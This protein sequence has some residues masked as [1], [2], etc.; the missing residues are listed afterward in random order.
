[1]IVKVPLVL[2]SCNSSTISLPSSA[3]LWVQM[4][5]CKYHLE[6]YFPKQLDF[7]T[8]YI[9]IPLTVVGRDY[10][11]TTNFSYQFTAIRGRQAAR[12]YYVAMCPLKLLPRIFLFDDIRFKFFLGNILIIE[13]RC[14]LL[15]KP[16]ILLQ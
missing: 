8:A 7:Q 10:V 12:E 1:M 4:E 5:V 11:G 2:G 9:I 14:R 6:V 16:L 3:H 15:M 13:D